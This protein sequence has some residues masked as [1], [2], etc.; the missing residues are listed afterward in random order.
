MTEGQWFEIVVG[1]ALT[2]IAGCMVRGY[3]WLKDLHVWH[4]KE[5]EEGVKVWY[6]RKSLED[7]VQRLA[8]AIDRID[9]RD[10]EHVA[11]LQAVVKS[12]EKLAERI[13]GIP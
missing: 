3:F 10:A 5:D 7:A 9:R 8:D 13:E 6:V 4:A 1:G 2:V 11:V 12:M